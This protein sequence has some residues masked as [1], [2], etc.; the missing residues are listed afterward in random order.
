MP[1]SIH[2]KKYSPS[3]SSIWTKCALSTLL[4]QGDDSFDSEAALFGTESHELAKTELA[5]ALHVIDYEEDV[6]S[7]EELKKKLPRYNE[8]M[9]A[10][11]D[12]YREAGVNLFNYYK[13]QTGED[14]LVYLETHI[15]MDFDDTAGGTLDFGLYS[16]KDGGT[17][18]VGDL[19]TG[20]KPLMA[21]DPENKKN[22]NSQLGLYAIYFYE[23]VIK[24]LYPVKNVRLIIYQP[25]INNTNEYSLSL[26]DLLKY[27]EE[28]I[29][30]AVLK[31]KVKD[32]EANAGSHCGYCAGRYV[33]T[34]Y[35]ESN[36]AIGDAV[37]K[38]IEEFSDEQIEEILPK[39]DA[40]IKYA[41]DLKEYAVIKAK[42]GHKWKG[43][44]LVPSK[45]SR[46][47]SDEEKVKKILEEN[48]I[49]PNSPG[50]LLGITEIQKKLGKEKFKELISPYV[51]LQESALILVPESDPRE[52]VVVTN[53][54]EK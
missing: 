17:I 24:G 31:T 49:N 5:E 50:K 53:K 4:N 33:C 42:E 30:P 12:Y 22:P 6:V 27:K 11:V 23:S 2:S 40:F 21:Y 48:G 19:K 13:N 47:I 52:E 15:D 1:P 29:I 8:D 28:V 9:Q 45:V 41:E 34:K 38:P 43:L 44:K 26:E 37:S 32:L 3:K 20:R 54:E 7:S 16:S 36:L 10:I 18:V 14:P 46:K 35:H 51:V 25:V 39:L